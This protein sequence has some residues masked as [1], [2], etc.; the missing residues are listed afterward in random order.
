MKTP[1][2]F[3]VDFPAQAAIEETNMAAG[4]PKGDSLAGKRIAVFIQSLTIGGAERMT[5]NLVEGLVKNDIQVDLLLA[6]RS[7]GF[8]SDV[9]SGVKGIDLKGK[10][11]LLSIFPL[12]HYLRKQCPDLLYSVQIHA[13]LIAIWAARL[14]R[15]PTKVVIS[16][17]NM[18][19]DSL[20]AA[21]TLR[22]KVLISLARRFF[23]FADAAI[24]VSQ[25]VA[26]DL[27][28]VTGMPRQKTYV[29]YNPV[30]SPAFEQ[31]AREPISHDWFL[32]GLPP[33]VLAVGR[34]AVAKDYPTLLRAFAIVNREQPARL[35]I[36]GDG[37]ERARLELFVKE[38]GLS[39]Q[40]Q[41]PGFVKNP[42]PYM[43][44]SRLLVLSSRWE[45]L[46]NVLVESLACGTP[47]VS[48]DCRSGPR[49][50]LD[51]GRFGRL[52][53]VGDA[54]ALAQAILESLHTT[55]DRSFLKKRAQDFSLEESVG[56]YT[57]IFEACLL[58]DE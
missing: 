37:Q 50:I 58:T 16:P 10:R 56:K 21:P 57:R 20:A 5:I 28:K 7:G 29:V 14:A 35:L 23:R 12:V 34:L 54:D 3:L 8:L 30:V 46:P 36:L 38:L 25:G 19:S 47:V 24:C 45:G 15:V 31:K 1:D 22:N 55:P 49:E 52:V 11:V 26:E 9:P 39:S 27:I 43:L 41:L 53:P 4:Q 44:Q 33:V 40:V 48:T 42:Y 6:D 17:R 18:L 13:S 51:N 2:K 32:P